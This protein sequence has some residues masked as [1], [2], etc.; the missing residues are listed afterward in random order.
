MPPS[1]QH[2]PP[3]HLQLLPT[4]NK[5]HP[6]TADCQ[7]PGLAPQCQY[8]RRLLHSKVQQRR[9]RNA[10]LLSHLGTG[11]GSQALQTVALRSTSTVSSE[12]PKNISYNTDM[13]DSR[14]PTAGSHLSAY[15]RLVPALSP[16][17]SSLHGPR[18]GGSAVRLEQQHCAP[19]LPERTFSAPQ[20]RSA[21]VKIGHWSPHGIRPSETDL[22]NH[23]QED[24]TVGWGARVSKRS[25]RVIWKDA[26]DNGGDG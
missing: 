12:H 19:S 25:C 9:Q 5:C 26:V 11:L 10:T 2:I 4:F 20:H 17:R 24:V 23:Q 21:F 8:F 1:H 15:E 3:H 7:P 22:V 14:S 6:G 13:N 16:P 18:G